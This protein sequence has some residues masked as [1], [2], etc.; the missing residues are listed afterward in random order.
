MEQKLN[1]EDIEDINVSGFDKMTRIGSIFVASKPLDESSES[2]LKKNNIST[3]IDMKCDGENSIDEKYFFDNVGIKY[4]QKRMKNL[5]DIDFNYLY[6]L[7]QILKNNN[8]NTLIYCVSGNRVSAMLGCYFCHNL[9][10]SKNVS[11]E[12]AKKVGITK[13][14]L[15]ESLKNKLQMS[16][17]S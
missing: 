12:T 1:L 6:E 13:E 17:C 10:H 9:G 11:L 3:A 15:Y 14:S 16:N 5:D 7:D 4:I 8:Q 2:F